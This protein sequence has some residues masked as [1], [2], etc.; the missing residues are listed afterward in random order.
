MLDDPRRPGVLRTM[1]ERTTAQQDTLD[2]EPDRRATNA[3]RCF[4]LTIAHHPDPARIGQRAILG[5]GPNPLGRLE[6]LYAAPGAEV[7]RTLGD[8]FVSR[9]PSVLSVEEDGAVRWRREDH[10]SGMLADGLPV[11]R[12]VRFGPDQLARG[13]VLELAERVVLVLSTRESRPTTTPGERFGLV[14]ESE[15]IERVRA[16]IRHV[17]DLDVPV[18][19]RGESGTGKELVAQA[20]HRASGREG[21]WVAVNVAALAPT[22][23]TEST[24]TTSTSCAT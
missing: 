20:L 12:S 1:V 5:R 2:R 19:L 11:A 16:A 3:E 17:A 9:R 24:A 15:A 7:G 4:L 18:L 21:Q 6:P 23:R 14:G 22:A 13:V 8:P 10:G